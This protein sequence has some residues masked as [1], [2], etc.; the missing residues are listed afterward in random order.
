MRVKLSY[1]RASRIQKPDIYSKEV[2]P[3]GRFYWF[4]WLPRF[5]NCRC[6]P[7]WQE[8]DGRFRVLGIEWLC[9][10]V[11]LTFFGKRLL[12]HKPQGAGVKRAFPP[13]T[14]PFDA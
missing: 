12:Q 14:N 2:Q 1:R 9:F 11:D 10:G 6:Q 4:Y 13:A 7:C 5:R 3:F 8:L